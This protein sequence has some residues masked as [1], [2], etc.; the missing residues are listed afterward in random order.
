MRKASAH[1]TVGTHCRRHC[2]KFFWWPFAKIAFTLTGEKVNSRQLSAWLFL[3]NNVVHMTFYFLIKA[4]WSLVRSVRS[5]NFA[6]MF[7]ECC[8]TFRHRKFCLSWNLRGNWTVCWGKYLKL[9]VNCSCL[10]L[11]IAVS[12]AIIVRCYGLLHGCLGEADTE[13]GLRLCSGWCSNLL[14]CWG[15]L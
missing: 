6:A 5:Y 15:C 9:L 3:Y 7:S 2:S 14:L 4:L 1:L 8:L 10:S 13:I 11:A 12:E